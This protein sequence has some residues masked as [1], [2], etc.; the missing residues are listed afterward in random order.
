[1]FQ[2]SIIIVYLLL[3]LEITDVL[4]VIRWGL[5]LTCSKYPRNIFA[6]GQTFVAM[7]KPIRGFHVMMYVQPAAILF[8]PRTDL[9]AS[10]APA[11][12]VYHIHR[13]P[14][15]GIAGCNPDPVLAVPDLLRAVL[16]CTVRGLEMGRSPVQGVLPTVQR[17][18][19]VKFNSESEMVR[20]SNP[21]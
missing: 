9:W 18:H 3:R 6:E 16:S 7:A 4:L 21:L 13:L 19:G 2:Y 15:A 10:S 11:T 14:N 5:G 12:C 20:A 8:L 1:M 17:I